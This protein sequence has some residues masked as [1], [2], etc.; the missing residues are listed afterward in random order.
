[1]GITGK[2]ETY[3]FSGWATR[4]NILC[5]DGRTIRHG[6][7]TDCC[8]KSVPLC[9]A[10]QHDGPNAVLGHAYLEDRPDGV[11]CYGSFNDTESGKEAKALVA[12]GDVTNLSIY[13][14]HLKE[15]AG[16]VMHGVIREVSLV[17]AGA[18]RGAYIDTVMCHGDGDDFEQTAEISM[19]DDM[20]LI[21]LA[22]A[23]GD[24]PDPK[25][26]PKDEGGKDMSA[27]NN[28]KT[29]QEVFDEM[30]EEQKTVVYAMVGAAVEKAKEEVDAAHEDYDEDGGNFMSH[31]LFEGDTGA[32]VLT[33]EDQEEILITA[34]NSSCGTLKE[35][36]LA[37]GIEN[38]EELYP[39]YHDTNTGEPE[40][41]T[42][43]Y[44]WVDKVI[45]GVHKAPYSRVRT[46]WAD[47]R[48]ADLA[49]G[50]DRSKNGGKKTNQKDIKLLKRTTDPQFIYVHDEMNREDKVD[51]TDFDAVNYQWKLMK[52]AYNETL[53]LAIMV[54]DQ[55][56]DEDP[57]KIY[58]EHIRPIWKDD[59][60]YTIHADVDFAAAKASLQG[61]D[62]NAHFGDNYIYAEAII[63]ASLH[64]REQYKGS[65]SLTFY[66]TPHL[67]N[68][69]LLARDLNGRRIYTSKQ[70]LAAAL[71]VNSIET[72]EQFEGLT[73]VVGEGVGAKTKK[74][75]GIFANLNDYQIGA[76]KGGE[77][78]TFSQFDI[79]FNKEKFLLEGRA[80]GA[81]TRVFSAIALEEDVTEA[82]AAG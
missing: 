59:D 81:M 43:D 44:T 63:E 47:A 64:A 55:R 32:T 7:F 29:V 56:D 28:E 21:E 40:T 30:T 23:D 65:G 4:H 51:I 58:E 70:D 76:T 45:A 52:Q 50:Y 2:P 36:F 18:N 35:A 82:Q 71:D 77:L 53:A 20:T 57:D 62:T 31:N 3:D 26:E 12:H 72:A 67:L 10:H 66:C 49:K 27:E 73:R 78:T 22:H 42:R 19:P 39:E 25:E 80:S 79:D 15:S 11:Y 17:L 61:T 48:Q 1:M 5:S 14:N 41:L 69:M 38:I 74:L 13:A 68:V 16:N 6:A 37:H 9:W 24:K 33:H 34:K 8:G 54:G 46:R 75:L 60:L